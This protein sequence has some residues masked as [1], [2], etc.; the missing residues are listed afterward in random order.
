[1]DV[2]PLPRNIMP[3][4][5]NLKELKGNV[6]DT[7]TTCTRTPENLQKSLET[8]RTLCFDH[9]KTPKM[10]RESRDASH[11]TDPRTSRS[12]SGSL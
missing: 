4:I 1:M 2:P 5:V 9:Y 10:Y 3:A 7:P 8:G 6:E 12:S 11:G